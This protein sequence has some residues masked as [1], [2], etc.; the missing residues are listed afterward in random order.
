MSQETM[1]TLKK[2][3]YGCKQEEI[4]E[5]EETQKKLNQNLQQ[6]DIVKTV[7]TKGSAVHLA[8]F[9][10]LQT[11]LVQ[12]RNQIDQEM[13]MAPSPTALTNHELLGKA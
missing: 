3:L 7:Q 5:Q 2:V 6:S 8:K 12:L 10:A 4:T 13:P 1:G 9:N 11:E